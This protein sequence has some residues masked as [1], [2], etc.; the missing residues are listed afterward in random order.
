MPQYVKCELC[1]LCGRHVYVLETCE[2]PGIW[3]Q[4][5]GSSRVSRT[6]MWLQLQSSYG[7]FRLLV[8]GSKGSHFGLGQ[9]GHSEYI[10]WQEKTVQ[11]GALTIRSVI[12]KYLTT[13][14]LYIVISKSGVFSTLVI[15]VLYIRWNYGAPCYCRTKLYGIQTHFVISPYTCLMM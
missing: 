8:S 3:S 14:T 1:V 2:E 13:E 7:W 15:A 4:I 5:P 6:Y 10:W 9:F 12:N 11:G